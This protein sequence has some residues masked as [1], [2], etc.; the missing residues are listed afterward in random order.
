VLC[1]VK[2]REMSRVGKNPVAIPGGVEVQV[3]DR[4][5]TVKG[6]KGQLS[7][8][9]PEKIKVKVEGGKAVAERP[10]DLKPTRALHGLTRNLI[11]NMVLGVSQ[12]YSK[13]LDLVGVGYR[14]Q[15]QGDKVVFNIGYSQPVEYRL[16]EGIKAEVDKKQVQLTVSGIDKQKVGQV[17]AEMKAI[18]PPDSYKGKGIRYSG[19]RLKLKAGKAAKK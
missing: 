3:R 5:V 8:R 15:V 18:R 14:A 2:E 7:W 4:L 13:V 12:G 11:Q 17:A 9:H 1:L 19:E 6:P 16:P 10:D